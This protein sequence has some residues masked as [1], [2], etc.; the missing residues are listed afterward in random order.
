MSMFSF[1][2]IGTPGSFFALFAE[3]IL[4]D[5]PELD[6]VLDSI[7]RM[8]PTLFGFLVCSIV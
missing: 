2:H 1:H 5:T 6:D 3:D 8:Y 7:D 4:L